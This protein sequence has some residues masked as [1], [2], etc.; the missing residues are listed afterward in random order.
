MGHETN[1]FALSRQE[2]QV[3]GSKSQPSSGKPRPDDT[4]GDSH[5]TAMADAEELRLAGDQSR[6]CGHGNESEADY[7]APRPLE[8]GWARYDLHATTWILLV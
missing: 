7:S 6:R 5:W 3:S 1:H 2:N 8:H 4:R